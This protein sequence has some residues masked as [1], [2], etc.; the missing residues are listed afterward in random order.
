MSEIFVLPKVIQPSVTISK[1]LIASVVVQPYTSA[2]IH[3]IV[4]FEEQSPTIISPSEN[5][6]CTTVF[7]PT[8]DYLKWQNDDSY[9]VDFVLSKLGLTKAQ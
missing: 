6:K 1:V 9:L 8:E 3:V 5:C 4:Y 2:S 7:M